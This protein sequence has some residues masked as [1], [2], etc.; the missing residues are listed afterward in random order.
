MQKVPAIFKVRQEQ[1][2]VDSE[3]FDSSQKNTRICALLTAKKNSQRLYNTVVDD[4]YGG[5]E[6]H[7]INTFNNTR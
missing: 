1:G 3:R 4:E 2:K 6:K 5:Q 7:T